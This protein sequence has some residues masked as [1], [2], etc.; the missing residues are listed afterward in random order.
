VIDSLGD[1]GIEIDFGNDQ[2]GA[3]LQRKD[4]GYWHDYL[5]DGKPV[6]NPFDVEMLPPGY[7]RLVECPV[8]Y[9]D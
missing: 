5:V 1:L 8:A 2:P 6:V 4:K 7:Y 9:T 3:I